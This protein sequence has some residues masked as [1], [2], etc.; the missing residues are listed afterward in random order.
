MSRDAESAASEVRVFWKRRNTYEWRLCTKGKVV[1][2]RG[3]AASFALAQ[4]EGE[5]RARLCPKLL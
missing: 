1:I 2:A 4:A 3:R 5:K